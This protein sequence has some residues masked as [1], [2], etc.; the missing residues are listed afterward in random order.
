MGHQ[1][2]PHSLPR[3]PI[4]RPPSQHLRRQ[5]P[6]H[7]RNILPSRFPARKKESNRRRAMYHTSNLGNACRR[8]LSRISQGIRRL[9]QQRTMP[10]MLPASRRTRATNQRRNKRSKIRRKRKNRN[11]IYKIESNL[12]RWIL[13]AQLSKR[14]YGIHEQH[15][16][17]TKKSNNQPRR[18]IKMPRPSLLN[19]QIPTSRNNRPKKS[20][21][22]QITIN[23]FNKQ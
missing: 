15:Q 4:K 5:Q 7:S 20:R 3:L 2:N 14:T 19:L 22:N 9:T 1:R 17:K 12:N 13:W 23:L 21:N 16:P 6:V 8:R 10:L 18:T 11:R